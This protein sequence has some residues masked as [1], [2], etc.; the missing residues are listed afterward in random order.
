MEQELEGIFNFLMIKKQQQNNPFLNMFFIS[1][2]K[3][4]LDHSLQHVVLKGMVAV[5]RNTN[6]P[7]EINQLYY[8]ILA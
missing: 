7:L 3:E 5:S 6:I 4:L 2:F 1:L 8:E